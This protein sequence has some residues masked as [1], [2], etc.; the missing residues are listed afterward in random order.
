MAPS[1]GSASSQALSSSDEVAVHQQSDSALVNAR[2][3]FKYLINPTTPAGDRPAR[4]RTRALL[5][6]LRYITQFIFWRLV[7]WAKYAA[8]GAV[9][10]AVGATAFGAFAS[11][12]GWVLAPPS[13]GASIVAMGIWKGGSF[14]AQR[15][16]RRWRE[17]GKDAG[18]EQRERQEDMSDEHVSTRAGRGLGPERGP[19]A[20]PW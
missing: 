8:V 10:A 19:Q 5:R 17:T 16:H 4:L 14:A 13:I 11:G 9:A 3:N 15:L 18:Q 2:R 6:S 20:V 1:R 7:R 12:I